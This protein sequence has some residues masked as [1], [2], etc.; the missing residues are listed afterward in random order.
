MAE[1]DRYR[2]HAEYFGST[3]LVRLDHM[4]FLLGHI[5]QGVLWVVRVDGDCDYMCTLVLDA[6]SY[7]VYLYSMCSN[8]LSADICFFL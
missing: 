1:F 6:E 3:I 5:R 2:M 8:I 4:V 7:G